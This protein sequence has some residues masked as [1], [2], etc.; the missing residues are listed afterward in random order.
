MTS[1]VR[2]MPRQARF[3]TFERPLI[4]AVSFSGKAAF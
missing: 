4:S 3:D 2:D 1:N